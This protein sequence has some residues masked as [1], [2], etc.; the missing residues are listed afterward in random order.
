MI[1]E[2][3]K[4]KNKVFQTQLIK[5]YISQLLGRQ[6]KRLAL[7]KTSR[8]GLSQK[9]AIPDDDLTVGKDDFWHPLPPK[10]LIRGVIHILMVGLGTYLKRGLGVE[11]NKI[12]I[13]SHCHRTLFWEKTK[14]LCRGCGDQFHEAIQAKAFF[15]NCF[16]KK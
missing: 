12:S 16:M 9:F 15:V 8:P 14:E 7:K 4:H 5:A 10:P 3:C 6:A 11:D 2:P 1:K 13:A